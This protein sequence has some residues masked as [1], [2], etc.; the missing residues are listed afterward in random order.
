MRSF[1]LLICLFA[2]IS[3][4][5]QTK[6]PLTHDV[7]DS[8]QSIQNQIITPNGKY[9]IYTLKPQEG[10]ATLQIQNITTPK[11]TTK[12][13]AR[14]EQARISMD[15]KFVVF[16][17]K[18]Q[19]DTTKHHKRKK[20]KEEK[21]PKDSLGIYAL[22]IDTLVKIPAV[23]SFQMPE[24]QGSFVAYLL[25][26][27]SPKKEK[28]DKKED[29]KGKK[30]KEKK[31]K[32]TAEKEN[33]KEEKKGKKENKKTE[34]KKEEN[35]KEDKKT[36]PLGAGGLNT[37]GE[38]PESDSLKNAGLE[39]LAELNKTKKDT[40]K[41]TPLQKA[42]EKIK[43]LEEKLAEIE[44]KNKPSKKTKA[45]KKESKDNGTK[46]VLRNLISAKQDTFLFVTQYNFDEKGTKL[47]F[48]STG[49]D[50]TFKAGAYIFDL[51]TQKLQ[52]ILSQ[53][54]QAKNLV[55]SE[56]GDQLAWVMHTDTTKKGEK[57]QIKNQKIFHWIDKQKE[58][59]M[60][61]DNGS[62]TQDWVIPADSRLT[63]S[64]SGERLF[65]TITPKPIE[66]DTSLLADEIVNVDVWSWQDNKLQPQQN[67]DLKDD[68]TPNYRALIYP[69]TKK[70]VYLA[71]L[72]M[73]TI[74]LSSAES[75]IALGISQIPYEKSFVWEGSGS[76]S[77]IYVVNLKDGKAKLAVKGIQGGAS[78][79]P[80]ADYFAWYNPKDSAW[81]AYNT[82]T[83][84]IKNLTKNLKNPFY[85][86]LWDMPANPSNYGQIG[87]TENDEHFLVND[88]YD[89]WQID[90]TLKKPAT[91]LTSNGNSSSKKGIASGRQQKISF[92]YRKL[93]REEKFIKPNQLLYFHATDE[94]TKA[95]GYFTL[96]YG[97]P[98]T[99]TKIV[100]DN[101][102]F[103]N[104]QKAKD[105]EKF[106]FTKE[107]FK[108]FPDVHITD[109][110]F[111]KITKISTANPQQ[112]KYLWGTVELVK[113]VSMTGEESHGLLY[114]PENFDAGKK[115]PMITY[116]YERHTDDLHDYVTPAPSASTIRASMYASNGYLVFMPDIPYK[117]GHPGESAYNSVVSGVTYLIGQGFVDKDKIGIQGQ[118][119]GGYQTAYLIT[120]TDLFSAAMAGAP[121]SNMTSAYGGIR[122]GSGNSRIS[123]YEKGQSR[124]G[125]TLW[126]KPNLYIENS[127]LFHAPKVKTPLLI[128]HNDKDGAVPWYQGIEYFMALKRL[129]KPVWMLTY[130]EEDHNLIQRKNRKDLSIR[131]QQFF[132][133][134]LKFEKMPKWMKEGVPAREKGIKRR[135]E[136]D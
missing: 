112:S 69:K 40:I 50:S 94:E 93:D 68:K 47:A 60:L 99:F 81:F 88:R 131:M 110:S 125:A 18:P 25:E 92:R 2:H 136:L 41:K 83:A 23:K 67:V 73:P 82:K 34:N 135:F 113:W 4:F 100:W 106:I 31:E 102:R 49:N 66:K 15:S 36:P 111:T 120:R 12:N 57:V 51:Q 17:I 52:H 115:Y 103:A 28:D 77:D 1:L 27:S 45:P 48:F 61:A 53:A 26:E 105:A 132:D 134:Y 5:A 119:W 84:E 126:E 21:H 20:T 109:N 89:V 116:F 3:L 108:D 16:K 30:E 14:G 117:T 86:E 39:E 13:I 33:K 123:Q 11:P 63:F 118:S 37:Q 96:T 6:K 29:K 7:Y 98:E 91:R 104:L 121:V 62:L 75:D 80:K 74:L 9:V 24:K 129:Q 124:I 64:E 32:K 90:P 72:D 76:Q 95:E 35:K 54:G 38:E 19:E 122:W 70:I 133:Y 44:N 22:E 43:K 10:D 65:F 85:D 130:N 42:E 46:L 107:T 59:S 79:S 128:M 97:K 78:I 101:C 87:W 8:W 55:F 56:K 58:A 114:K 71:N 127:P